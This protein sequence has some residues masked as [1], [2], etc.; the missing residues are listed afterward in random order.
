M[1][2]EMFY[3]VFY[4]IATVTLWEVAY[5]QGKR[6]KRKEGYKEGRSDGGKE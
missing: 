6:D 5:S 4:F 2:E 3:A 1:I